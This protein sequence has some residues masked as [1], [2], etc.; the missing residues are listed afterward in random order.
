[1]ISTLPSRKHDVNGTVTPVIIFTD[2]AWEQEQASAG[3]VVID[4]ESRK[5][6]AVSVPDSLVS[7]WLEEAGDQIISRIELWAFVVVK[8]CLKKFLCHRRGIAWID[9]EAARA[10]AIKANSPSPTMKSLARV[11]SD[12]DES[13][14]TMSW[15]ERV[16]SFSNPADLPSSGRIAEAVTLY[17]L[18]DAGILS[19]DD[20]FVGRLL[21]LTHDPY[22]VAPTQ[23]GANN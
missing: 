9:N 6:Y 4:G 13:F 2:G 15:F 21:Q 3:A 8:W 20:E 5:A 1:M 11:L 17:N 16:C 22:Q 10:C 18:T 12:I 19:C 14:P 7:H 23:S